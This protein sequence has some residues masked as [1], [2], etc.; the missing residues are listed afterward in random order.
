VAVSFDLFGTLVSVARPPEPATAVAYELRARGI[1]VPDS[2]RET[3]HSLH[4][5][6]PDGRELPLPDHVS[7]A[8]E[9]RGVDAAEETVRRAVIAAFDR[10]VE[11]RP[12]AE[13]ALE[14]AVSRGRVGIYSN[15]SVP[16]LVGLVLDGSDV[17]RDCFDAVVTSAACG[18][19]KPDSRAFEA[20]ADE[21]NV[22]LEDLIHVG[23]DP[24]ADGGIEDAGGQAILLT[25]HDL[26][27]LPR[28]LEGVQ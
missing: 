4:V 18:W 1:D 5:E 11:T 21:L 10:E 3:Y 7:A 17:D 25:E 28:L 15:C 12:G 14:A 6:V 13:Q 24:E 22:R 19:R 23:D 26:S 8:L 20:V 16:G 2:W 27:D 9:S